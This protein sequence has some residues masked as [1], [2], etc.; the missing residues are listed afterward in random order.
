MKRF[1]FLIS[2]FAVGA[3][4]AQAPNAGDIVSRMSAA[5]ASLNSY[6]V[7]VGF[8]FNVHAFFTVHFSPQATYYFKRPDKNELVFDSLPPGAQQFQRFFGSIGTP[9]TWPKTYD[10]TLAGSSGTGPGE[11]YDLRMVPKDQ[12]SSVAHV[13]VLVDAQSLGVVKE[14]WYYRDG[15][16]ISMDQVN[17]RVGGYLLPKEQIADFNFPSYKAHAVSNFDGYH[18]NAD[19][20][21][22]VFAG[23]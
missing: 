8:Q 16:T 17:E 9:E 13:D 10:I 14:Q 22:S 11:R 1:I 23:K 18:L 20:P 15:A 5:R 21:D 12:T 6:S 7:R 4:P 2:L 19:I 3:A